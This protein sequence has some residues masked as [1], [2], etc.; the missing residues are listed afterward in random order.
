MA[1][2]FHHP[3]GTV[4]LGDYLNSH[5]SDKRWTLFR[6][7]IAFVK[8]SG[9]RHIRKCLT[10][11][12]QRADVKLS[13]GV[14]F[15]GTS[16]EGLQDLLECLEGRGAIWIY[17]NE[18]Y[19]TFH[20]KIYMFRNESHAD[21]LVGSGNLTEGGLYTNYEAS[22]SVSLDLAV[23]ADAIMLSQIEGVLDSWSNLSR[24]T[25]AA[26][27]LTD[28]LL[29]ELM[30]NGYVPTEVQARVAA[31]DADNILRAGSGI[32]PAPLF[33]RMPV[34]RAPAL[35]SSIPDEPDDLREEDYEI[36]SPEAVM[37]QLGHSTGFLMTLQKTDV[38]VGQTTQGTARRSPEVFIPLSAR[39]Y[40][41]DFWGWNDLFTEDSAR[42]GKW[43]RSA[44]PC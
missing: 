30:T 41:P 8:R 42:A 18:N 5:L 37:T 11:F 21:V 19:S 29:A 39:D 36:T 13:I 20:P 10:T 33:K 6:A 38:G 28:E 25:G 9:V 34:P 27:E 1:D 32:R 26:R 14:D 12:S 43:D 44:V 31:Q 2:F 23:E 24:D 15:G 7:A 22:L 40:D 4:R 35:L 3:V 16:M 17:H